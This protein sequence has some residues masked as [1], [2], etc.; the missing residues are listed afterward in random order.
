MEKKGPIVR[1]SRKLFEGFMP[2]RK[3]KLGKNPG[4]GGSA[5]PETG[6]DSIIMLRRLIGV[7]QGQPVR[8]CW[9]ICDG[10]TMVM[11]RRSSTLKRVSIIEVGDC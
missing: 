5:V 9:G 4:T 10:P 6:A 3:A 2:S 1:H 11:S 8:V 7:N